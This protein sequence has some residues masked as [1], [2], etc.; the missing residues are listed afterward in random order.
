M[1]DNIIDEYIT[2]L[3]IKIS[4]RFDIDED[5]IKQDWELFNSNTC[6]YVYSKGSKKGECCENHTHKLDEGFCKYHKQYEQPKKKRIILKKFLD[7]YYY[8]PITNLVFSKE[9]RV[10]GFRCNEKIKDLD[11]E[12]RNLCLIWKFKII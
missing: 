2:I 11:E 5:D 8:H 9:R 7:N 6:C 10:I 4:R 1:F 3:N 12:H